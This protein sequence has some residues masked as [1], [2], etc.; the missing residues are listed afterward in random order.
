MAIMLMF[1]G[2]TNGIQVMWPRLK[3]SDLD[4][5]KTSQPTNSIFSIRGKYILYLRCSSSP[6]I[7]EKLSFFLSGNQELFLQ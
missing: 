6:S 2:K 4:I 3:S 5:L 1:S 7:S